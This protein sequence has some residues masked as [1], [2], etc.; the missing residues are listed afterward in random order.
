MTINE[1]YAAIESGKRVFWEN[2]D[3]EVLIENDTL[4]EYNKNSFRNNQVLVIRYIP[5]FFGGLIHETD[6]KDCFIKE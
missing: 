4:N 3:Y 1:I 6:L 2:N 5:N